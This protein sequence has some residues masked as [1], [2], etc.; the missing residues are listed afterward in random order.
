MNDHR[1]MSLVMNITEGTQ[2]W[3]IHTPKNSNFLEFWDDR[4]Q[5]R[6][7]EAILDESEDGIWL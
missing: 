1:E 6:L 3:E 2:M 7:H 5:Q 4:G